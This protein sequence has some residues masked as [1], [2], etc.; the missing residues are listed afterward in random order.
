MPVQLHTATSNETEALIALLMDAEEGEER[1]Y[2]TVTDPAHTNYLAY[3]GDQV[4]RYEV[5][6]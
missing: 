1:I 3:N 4:L 2:R 6:E 5:E